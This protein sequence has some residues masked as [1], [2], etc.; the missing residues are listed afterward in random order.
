[1]HRRLLVVAVVV[2]VIGVSLVLVNRQQTREQTRIPDADTETVVIP[3]DDFPQAFSSV[4]QIHADVDVAVD[5][6]KDCSQKQSEIVAIESEEQHKARAL[7]VAA[8]LANSDDADYLLAAA[9]LVQFGEPDAPLE[10]LRRASKIAPRH[11]L[12]AWS[13]L[14]M[15]RDRKG[16]RCDLEALEANAIEVDGSN[17]AVWMEIAMLRLAEAQPVAASDA[18][19]R[20]IAAPRFDSY[21]ID[22]ALVFERALSTNGDRSYRDRIFAGIGYSAAL[23]ISYGAI[24][25][26]CRAV[27]AGGVWLELCD[28][29]GEKMMTDG[30]A[31]M[32]QAIGSALR[33]IAAERSGD[34]EWRQRATAEYEAF[35]EHYQSF[36]AS[37]AMQ[38][39]LENDEA[40]LRNYVE[41]FVTYGELEAQMRLKDDA[42]RLQDDP[43]YDQCNFVRRLAFD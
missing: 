10:L 30:R 1:M 36:M 37:G 28:Q 11:P 7:A 25:K 21:F 40:V 18:V 31:L 13:L 43:T 16:A 24:T 35:R 23:V 26:H 38:T 22:H 32:D 12:V 2:A 6:S 3:G 14:A 42:N 4:P 41:N 17:G 27:D 33:K 29:L 39:L 5:A 20:A 19:R 15:C 9:L 34:E 8:E